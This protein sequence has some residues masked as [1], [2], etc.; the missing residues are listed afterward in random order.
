MSVR[1]NK[2]DGVYSFD[3]SKEYVPYPLTYFSSSKRFKINP[4]KGTSY[5]GFITHHYADKK[6]GDILFYTGSI[7]PYFSIITDIKYDWRTELEMYSVNGH[8][9]FLFFA[10]DY[11][12]LVIESFIE[13]YHN[14]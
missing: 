14:E 2:G 1:T 3:G 10:S 9:K 7:N 13:M 12:S 8:N 11:W 5:L 6:V 4:E